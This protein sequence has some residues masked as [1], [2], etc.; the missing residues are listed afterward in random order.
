MLDVKTRSEIVDGQTFY[1]RPD[2]IEGPRFQLPADI[3]AVRIETYGLMDYT[4]ETPLL[5]RRS[6][7]GAGPGKGGIQ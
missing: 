4:L 6:R 1:E 5:T 3:E 2:S 7:R